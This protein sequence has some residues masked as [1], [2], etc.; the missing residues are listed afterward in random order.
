MNYKEKKRDVEIKKK[1]SDIVV[2]RWLAMQI[3]P[4][5]RNYPCAKFSRDG[6]KVLPNG[7]IKSDILLI[8]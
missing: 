4:V 2:K 5:K 6:V 1:G 3:P 7:K 8:I